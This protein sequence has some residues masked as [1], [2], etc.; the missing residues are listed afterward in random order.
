MGRVRHAKDF[1]KE[2]NKIQDL[3]KSGRTNNLIPVKVAILDT[4]IHQSHRLRQK[5]DGYHDFVDAD[6]VEGKTPARDDTGHGSDMV[7][8]LYKTAPSAS[9]YVGRVFA[10]NNGDLDT[11]VRVAKVSQSFI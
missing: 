6:F 5:L 8:L 11:A 3:L 10:K 1:F 4:S 9:I 2:I 7:E